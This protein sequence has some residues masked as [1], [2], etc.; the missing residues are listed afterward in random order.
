MTP[1][2]TE[3]EGDGFALG[4]G[5]ARAL[6]GVRECDGGAVSRRCNDPAA[7]LRRSV[8]LQHDEGGIENAKSLRSG[9]VSLNP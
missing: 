7:P 4:E 8:N 2:I 5:K 6:F 9:C 1:C 3:D